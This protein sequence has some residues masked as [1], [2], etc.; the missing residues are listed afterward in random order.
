MAPEP[1]A[2]IAT[3]AG[4]THVA[5]RDFRAVRVAAE[6]VRTGHEADARSSIDHWRHR[7][8]AGLR[9]IAAGAATAIAMIG[10]AVSGIGTTE[11]G[12]IGTAGDGTAAARA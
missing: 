10:I 8:A 12:A 4:A 1:L 6:G 9:A 7:T 2:A 3:V 11:I 5:A